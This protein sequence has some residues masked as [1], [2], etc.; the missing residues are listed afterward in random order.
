M[1]KIK[2]YLRW[3]RYKTQ[4]PVPFKR[5]QKLRSKETV[6]S[7]SL[8]G[9]DDNKCI[10]VHIPKT[11]GVSISKALF[12]NYGGS[13]RTI[14]DYMLIFNPIEFSNYFKF[15]FVRNPWDRLVSAFF[16]LKAGGFEESD[17]KWSETHL[18]PYTNF[19]VFVREWVNEKNILLYPHFKPQH[20]F[21]C[22]I[23]NT[24]PI[25]F[26]GFYENLYSDFNF[27]CEKLNIKNNIKILNKSNH[28]DYTKLY[29]KESIKIV[30]NVYSKDIELFKYTFDNK[31]LE[32]Q[33]NKRI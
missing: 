22:A 27:I 2:Q 4:N 18:K 33:L 15:T 32:E 26:I 10:F 8:K 14:E 11:G 19:N 12:N 23:N 6:D 3:Y 24:I 9:F 16:F 28:Q 1:N 7:W 17:R 31:F 29:D 25:D 21:I 20:S 30:A 5:S 13:H